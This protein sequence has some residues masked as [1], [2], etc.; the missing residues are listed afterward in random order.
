MGQFIICLMASMG[1]QRRSKWYRR[2]RYGD[3]LTPEGQMPFGESLLPVLL[4]NLPST[5]LMHL[6]EAVGPMLSF[7]L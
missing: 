3:E 6:R 2:I 5:T 7:H 4:A 1:H